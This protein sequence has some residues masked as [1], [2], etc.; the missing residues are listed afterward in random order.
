MQDFIQLMITSMELK[1]FAK[2]TQKTYLGHI[3][4]FAEFYANYP[5]SA[6]YDDIRD[7]LHHSITKRKLSLSLC[8]FFAY[9]VIKFFFQSAL[10]REWNMLHV[11]RLKKKYSLPIVLTPQEV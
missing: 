5:A 10:C 6:G 9:G 3:R 7:F 1:G 4:C 11:P 2:N 8:E